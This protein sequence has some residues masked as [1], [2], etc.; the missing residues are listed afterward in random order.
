LQE[1]TEAQYRRQEKLMQESD[2][3]EFSSL[4]M[5]NAEANYNAALQE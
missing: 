1:Q 3:S 4:K 5:H 2:F